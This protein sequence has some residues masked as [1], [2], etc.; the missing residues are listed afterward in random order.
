MA[1]T[2]TSEVLEAPV[3]TY[4]TGA[5]N[6][7]TCSC[8]YQIK[9][10]LEEVLLELSSAKE[11]IKILQEDRNFNVSTDMSNANHGL[12][13]DQFKNKFDSWAQVPSN[14]SKRSRKSHMQYPQLIP[15]IIRGAT[16]KFPKFECRAKTA[17]STVVGL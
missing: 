2:K 16:Q 17:C 7:I 3:L 12:E 4:T 5:N 6:E 11:I 14:R 13:P 10:K 9:L 15:T 1:N 8:C